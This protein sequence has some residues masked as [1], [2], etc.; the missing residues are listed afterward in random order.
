MKGKERD[1]KEFG[2]MFSEAEKSQH[3]QPFSW[4][5]GK[6]NGMAFHDLGSEVTEY[7]Y[8]YI[9]HRVCTD[10]YTYYIMYCILYG[11]YTYYI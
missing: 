2:H 11:I 9:S 5:S 7:I 3:L 6:A 8:I 4:R 1:Y 10:T